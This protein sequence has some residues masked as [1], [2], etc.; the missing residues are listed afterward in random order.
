MSRPGV[1]RQAAAYQERA[2]EMAERMWQM[3][4]ETGGLQI[5]LRPGTWQACE[6][7]VP[8]GGG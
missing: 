1:A 2:K 7:L 3:L 4:E 8:F 5:P 6:R